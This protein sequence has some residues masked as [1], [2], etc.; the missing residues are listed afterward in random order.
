MIEWGFV[1]PDEEI[2]CRTARQFMIAIFTGHNHIKASLVHSTEGL[3]RWSK[4]NCGGTAI[5]LIMKNGESIANLL[6]K[7]VKIVI[8]MQ[9]YGDK[10]TNQTTVENIM[11]V[12]NIEESKDL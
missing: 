5:T 9:S 8:K 4:G 11:Q 3:W 1:D 2:E 12:T 7:A 6:S 10:V